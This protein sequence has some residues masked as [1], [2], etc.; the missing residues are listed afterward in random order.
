MANRTRQ[1]DTVNLVLPVSIAAGLSLAMMLAWVIQRAT[2][3]SGWIDMIWSFAVGVGGVAVAIF[4]DGDAG[5]RATVFILVAIWSARLGGHIGA[6]TKSGGEDPRYAKFIAEWGASAAWK[7]F[8]FL[9]VQALAALVLV[10][11]IGVAAANPAPFPHLLDM[12]GIVIAVVGIG[13]ETLADAELARFRRSPEAKTGVCETGFWRYSRHPNYFFEWLGWCAWLFFA[14]DPSGAFPWG[15][16]A[17]I[18][19]V[20]M[21][22]LL[23]HVSGIPPL[24]EHMLRSRGEKFR[25]LQRR[26]NAF[27]PGPRRSGKNS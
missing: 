8:V 27:F 23:A 16:L 18:A 25:A 10:L 19:P 4:A 9:Q 6:R 15:W 21:Y 2:G 24:E 26:V 17:L 20:L 11:A 3:A 13:G 1:G 12:I 14:I 7:L 22:W 5:R